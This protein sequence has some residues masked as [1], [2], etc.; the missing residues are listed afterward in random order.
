MRKWMLALLCIPLIGL[1]QIKVEDLKFDKDLYEFGEIREL[2]GRVE[3]SFKFT[4]KGS[5]YFLI[6]KV[7]VA[8]GCTNPEWPRD[9]IYPNQ[10]GEIKVV[11][12]PKGFE[13]EVKKW[14][15]INGNFTDYPTKKLI[16]KADVKK[17]VHKDAEKYYPGMYGY[18]VQL[19]KG[20]DFGTVYK[21]LEIKDS[22]PWRNDGPRD[23][24]ITS[25]TDIPPFMEVLN[26]PIT[27]K[28]GETKYIKVKLLTDKINDYGF[29]NGRFII[30]TTDQFYKSKMVDFTY[31]LEFDFNKLTK[32]EIRRS[33]RAEIS[34][35]KV[36]MGEI[37]T[38]TKVSKK[39]QISNTGKSDLEII[40]VVSN[41]GC[42]FLSDY[43][44]KIAPGET[45]NITV[46]FDSLFKDGLNQKGITIYTTDPKNPAITLT[47][48]AVVL[49]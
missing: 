5:G 41:C 33:G 37:P 43:P 22:M 45:K 19:T 14:I 2:G 40:N 6:S 31:N 49:E 30:H 29:D 17:K 13:G 9:T 27:F 15:H 8:C 28:P 39:I 34:E 47:V 21:G 12:N 4:N 11:F 36:K 7:D 25:A 16:I 42:A 26:L 46:T 1:G 44:K 35:I 38:G 3:T 10:S 24:S 18:I 20:L 23:F 48:Q 32:K